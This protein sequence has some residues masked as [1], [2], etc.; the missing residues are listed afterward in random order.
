[1]DTFQ[2]MLIKVNQRVQE[3][4]GVQSLLTEFGC[5]IK[6]RLG[7]H[8]AGD[9]CSN[10]GLIVLQLTGEGTE[11]ENFAAKLNALEG[12]TARLTEI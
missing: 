6:M 12:V 10:Q 7:L 5:H 2:I 9:H 3:A 8:E 11:L 4:A 1:M